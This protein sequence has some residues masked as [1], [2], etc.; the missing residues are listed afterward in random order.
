M[1][2][3]TRPLGRKPGEDTLLRS[4][5]TLAW[6]VA[7]LLAALLVSSHP[8]RNA[9]LWWHLA[10][11]RRIWISGEMA[12]LDPFS[13]PPLTRIWHNHEWLADLLLYAWSHSLGT[14]NLWIW[15]QLT[16]AAT[17][18]LLFRLL[19]RES[20]RFAVAAL[21]SIAALAMVQPFVELRPHLLSLL[22]FVLLLTWWRSESRSTSRGR[23]ALGVLFVLWANLHR[24]APFGLAALAVLLGAEALVA[25]AREPKPLRRTRALAAAL[26]LGSYLLPA[27]LATLIHPEPI[28]QFLL[29]WRFAASSSPFHS[30]QEWLSPFSPDGIGV[31][32]FPLVLTGY[33][34]ILVA[35]LWRLRGRVPLPV[36]RPLWA[37][38]GL[39]LL[40]CGM[41]LRASRF[42]PL[43]G[44]G[45]ALLLAEVFRADPQA[46]PRRK[47]TAPRPGFLLLGVPVGL[48]VILAACLARYPFGPGTFA[49]LVGEE[50]FP[51][52]VMDR[53]ER[54]GWSG[55][56]YAYFGWGGYL[57]WRT[58]GRL[59]VAID[60]RADTVFD[61]PTY[62]AY[63]RVQYGRGDWI[64]VVERSGA[65]FFL[66]P[67]TETPQLPWVGQVDALL[68]TGRWRKVAEDFVG[69]MLVRADSPV[70][71]ALPVRRSQ[72]LYQLMSKAR[73]AMDEGDGPRA[74]GLLRNALEKDPHALIACRNLAIVIAHRGDIDGAWQQRRR[75]NRIF[76]E[77]EGDA[78]L[79][80]YIE[81]R[82][83][84]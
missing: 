11:G 63:R 83:S 24:S 69:A 31:P 12:S 80:R 59:P 29:P 55:P 73:E 37:A 49:L 84:R 7:A 82:A 9:D 67:T 58:D 52:D 27:F 10:A 21:G 25:V 39:S 48:C 1:A 33:C 35:A 72:S 23:I 57:H 76:P 60:S 20:G 79:A 28:Y 65:R 4:F 51:V 70:V 46:S 8:M 2:M 61:G 64:Q 34:A 56:V 71:P 30:L 3:S 40:T 6:H 75:C 32:A 16:L 81:S 22:A 78:D 15:L 77:P 44:I 26:E 47:V 66:W 62:E 5:T 19:W 43:F 36:L 13:F 50:S 53:A 17:Y 68:A 42:L 54:A 45:A 74:E 14:E 18:V 38:L 41:A